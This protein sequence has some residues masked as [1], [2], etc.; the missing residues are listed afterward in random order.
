MT[1]KNTFSTACSV[2]TSKLQGKL[3]VS[4][5]RSAEFRCP[6]IYEKASIQKHSDAWDD[7]NRHNPRQTRQWTKHLPRQLNGA[8]ILLYSPNLCYRSARIR[9]CRLFRSA[10]DTSWLRIQA[11]PIQPMLL[12]PR[13]AFRRLQF[14][15]V[16]Q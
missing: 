10:L 3:G 11:F 8:N 1:K 13:P 7:R 14:P 15:R 16:S 9:V 4:P 6:F 2:A 12:K 5:R